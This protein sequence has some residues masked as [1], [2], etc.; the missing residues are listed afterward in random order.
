MRRRI[1]I[2]PAGWSAALLLLA[3]CGGPRSS[4]EGAVQTFLDALDDGDST[5]FA[6]SFTPGT[7]EVV[8]EL[9]ELSRAVTETSGHPAITIDDWCRAFCGGTVEGSTLHG[10]AAT[11]RV[12]VASTVE[13]IP[14]VRQE[15]EWR[16]DLE[17]RYRP[18]VELLWLMAQEEAAAD[19]TADSTGAVAPVG[20]VEAPPDTAPER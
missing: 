1:G 12:R 5:R 16:I 10:D 20:G 4:P 2:G 8:A 6:A 18:A 11:V 17:E 13:E 14:L 7:R 15:N 9:E 3:A 19:T